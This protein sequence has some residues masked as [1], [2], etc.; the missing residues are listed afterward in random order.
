MDP[1]E[2]ALFLLRRLEK[3]KKGEPLESAP[4]ESRKQEDSLPEAWERR[5]SGASCAQAA[6]ASLSN[7]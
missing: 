2:G 5:L 1:R 4:E 6:S 3:I 7:N